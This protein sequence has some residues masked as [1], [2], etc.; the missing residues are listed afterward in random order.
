MF[1]AQCVGTVGPRRNTV[2]PEKNDDALV[3]CSDMQDG[4]ATSCPGTV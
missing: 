4:F 2:L 3:G 1:R